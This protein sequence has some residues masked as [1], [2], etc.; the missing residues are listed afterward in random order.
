MLRELYDNF[1]AR[2]SPSYKEVNVNV[3]SGVWQSITISPNVFTAALEN[4]MRDLEW[5]DL[6]VKNTEHRA[7]GTNVGRIR[8]CFWE[9]RLKTEPNEEDAHDERIG[10]SCSFSLDE[11]N[12]SES[13]SSES[14]FHYRM[15]T[16]DAIAHAME[17]K[18]RWSTHVVRYCDDR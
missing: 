5:E 2:I 7:G 11:T 3:K 18:I 15:K 4:I 17:S 16:K 9:D 12:V 13:R 14:E 8:Q 1:R 10:T 6:G